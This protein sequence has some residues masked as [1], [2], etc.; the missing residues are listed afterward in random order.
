MIEKIWKVLDDL[1][2]GEEQNKKIL[3]YIMLSTKLKERGKTAP[4]GCYI[5]GDSAGGKTHLVREVSKLFP[6]RMKLFFGGSSGKTLRYLDGK[7]EPLEEYGKNENG[8]WKRWKKIVDLSGKIL[9]FL[10]DVG[11]EEV[12]KD[13]RPILSRDQKEI[14]FTTVVKNRSKK[15]G[16]F[17]GNQDVYIRGCPSFVTTSTKGE[18]LKETGTRVI[19]LSPDESKE[20]SR[21]I[22]KSKYEKEKFYWEEENYEDIHDFIDSLESKDVYVCFGDLLEFPLDNLNIRRDFDKIINLVKVSALLN[23]KDRK[24]ITLKGKPVL[25]ATTEDLCIILDL[26]L[27]ILKPTLMNLPKKLVTFYDWLIQYKEQHPEFE[28]TNTNIAKVKGL[29]QPAVR[30]YC[31]NLVNSGKLLMTKEGSV[32][33]YEIYNKEYNNVTNVTKDMV[34]LNMIVRSL[35][36]SEF[37]ISGSVTKTIDIIYLWGI[38]EYIYTFLVTLITPLNFEE[39]KSI[40][41]KN[42]VLE[43]SNISETQVTLTEQLQICSKCGKYHNNT[44]DCQ[45]LLKKIEEEMVHD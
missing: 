39:I 35:K 41:L 8:E 42:E 36:S 27:P 26:I 21:K 1:I 45:K 18:I 38:L 43:K 5:T 25:V 2:V 22:V 30:N 11:S 14:H 6:D 34:T 33:Y 23:Q 40:T 9:W 20:Q 10:E 19:Q 29:S 44:M 24:E 31:W 17:Y 16:E 15:G 32:N 4:L 37:A 3:F 28:L 13:L 12:F 7:L